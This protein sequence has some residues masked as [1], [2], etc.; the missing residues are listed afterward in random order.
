MFELDYG[1]SAIA[2]RPALG[3]QTT[4]GFGQGGFALPRYDP[5]NGEDVSKG[6]LHYLMER[7]RD[8]CLRF[9][10]GPVYI[11][12]G[13]ETH[14]YAF[15]LKTA[16][17]LPSELRGPLVVRIYSS[18]QGLPRA[19]H[20]FE[21]QQ[22]L[23]KRGFPAPFPAFLEEDCTLFG[24]P[25]LVMEQVQ[26][27][28]LVEFLSRTPL[29]LWPTAYQMALTQIQ[30][31][32]LPTRNFPAPSESFLD[33][34]LEEIQDL[35]EEYN[36]PGLAPGLGWLKEHR[37][38]EPDKPSILHLDYHPLNLMRCPDGA[39]AVLDWPEAD[40][41]DFHADFATTLMLMDC[42][43]VGENSLFDQVLLP[44]GRSLLRMW[45]S[46]EYKKRMRVDEQ[47]LRYY[48]GL[49]ALRRLAGYGR[50]LN[51]SPLSTGCKPSSI[52]Y[53]CPHHLKVLQAYFRK[54]TGVGVNLI[55]ERR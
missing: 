17:G 52:R 47:R 40:I 30:L 48:K 45:Y 24:G 26:G 50:W 37:P 28:T 4:K 19:R 44:I 9:S 16:D 5:G 51:A 33:R 18:S 55:R 20:E 46:Y 41:G 10:E 21:V 38:P 7:Y 1:A 49:A 42:C 54:N 23:V 2:F 14:T 11:P 3:P 32:Q 13:W 27:W 29:W 12:N 39:M 8:V 25:F 15:R 31:H 36:L 34:R 43:P 22:H 6:F 53:L 35:L